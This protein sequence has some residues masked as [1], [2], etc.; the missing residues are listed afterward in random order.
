[1]IIKIIEQTSWFRYSGDLSVTR[2][3]YDRKFPFLSI[4]CTVFEYDMLIKRSKLSLW[5]STQSYFPRYASLWPLSTSKMTFVYYHTQPDS[6]EAYFHHVSL[7]LSNT[8]CLLTLFLFICCLHCWKGM[9]FMFIAFQTNWNI[10]CFSK[11]LIVLIM[12]RHTTFV[13][14]RI[15][16]IPSVVCYNGVYMSRSI[17]GF[18][19]HKSWWQEWQWYSTF[20]EPHNLRTVQYLVLK[21]VFHWWSILWILIWYVNKKKHTVIVNLNSQSYRSSYASLWPLSTSK[22]LSIIIPNWTF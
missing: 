20:P 4:I 15:D 11:Y 2:N 13:F 19:L 3:K 18:S 14:W 8:I 16:K 6:L 22:L 9:D 21:W 17:T 5:I 10:A 1:M 12:M 7:C